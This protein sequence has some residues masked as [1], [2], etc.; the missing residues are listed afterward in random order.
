MLKALRKLQRVG[1][2]K[3]TSGA[4]FSGGGE[5]G[6]GYGGWKEG[7][8]MRGLVVMEDAVGGAADE[9]PA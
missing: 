4:G 2:V 6:D 1:V 5:V 7:E 8:A 9:G 3:R